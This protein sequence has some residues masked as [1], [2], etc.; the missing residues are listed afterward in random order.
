MATPAPAAPETSLHEDLGH[1]REELSK[2]TPTSD[3]PTPKEEAPK[4][5]VEDFIENATAEELELIKKDPVLAKAHKSMLRDYKGKTTDLSKQRDALAA[6]KAEIE[7]QRE[8][9][10]D[11]RELLDALRDNPE[12]LIKELAERRGMTVA[13]VKKEA[14]KVETDAD[15]VAL[16]GDDA[17]TI[18][19]TFDSAVNKRV[20]EAIRPVVG[21]IQ[22]EAERQG[23]IKIATDIQSL[24]A[25][26]KEAGEEITPEIESEM[27]KLTKQLDPAIDPE[28]GKSIT[29]KEYLRLLYRVATAGKS[30]AA[31]VKEVV[32]RQAKNLRDKEPAE[33]PSGGSSGGSAITDGM[34]L[35][36]SLKV[37]RREV[38]AGR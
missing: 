27:Q 3:T 9:A 31:V 12:K 38:K 7:A 23:R 21:W 11:A 10:K 14:A 32:D 37:A 8:E 13:E 30:R 36:E 22:Q 17:A 35:R 1:A 29:S 33:I 20:Q 15:L 2:E 34:N 16:F 4:G 5:D 24:Q 28:T 26:L 19:P 6:E 25:E 18:Q